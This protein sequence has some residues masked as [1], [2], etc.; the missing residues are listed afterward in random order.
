MVFNRSET[1]VQ[2]SHSLHQE[3]HAAHCFVVGFTW[4]L[5]IQASSSKH[6]VWTDHLRILVRLVETVLMPVSFVFL[7]DR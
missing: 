3:A 4:G 1:F 5:S 6:L 7:N 2:G